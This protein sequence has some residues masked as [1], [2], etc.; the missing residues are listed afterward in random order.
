MGPEGEEA[1][2]Y[3][4]KKA[5]ELIVELKPGYDYSND[6]YNNIIDEIIIFSN[7][8][9]DENKLHVGSN[10]SDVMAAYSNELYIVYN[11]DERIVLNPLSDERIQYFVDKECY[12]GQLPEVNSIEGTELE[13]PTFKPDAVVSKIRIF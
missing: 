13:N 1:I 7:K 2:K 5:D 3:A 6:N 11:I 10:V 12:D 4:I 9:R 8:Y